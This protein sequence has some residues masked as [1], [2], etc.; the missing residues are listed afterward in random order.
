MRAVIQRVT[1]AAVTVNLVP[2]SAIGKGLLVFLG[3]EEQ[4]ADRD[5]AYMVDKIPNLRIFE[6]GDG[7]MNL[8]L[9]DTGGE[10]LIISQFTLFGDCRKGR[11]PGFTSAARPEKANAFYRSVIEQCRALGIRVSEGV[12]QADM[13][14]QILNDGPVTIL[15]DS[16]KLF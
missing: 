11:R 1:N 4:D 3:V 14:V 13:Q 12:F 6:D 9:V 10:L 8:S 7:K 2:V 16:K 5:I 15:L